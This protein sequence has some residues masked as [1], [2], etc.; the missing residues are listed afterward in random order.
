MVIKTN[1]PEG[2][3]DVNDQDPLSQTVPLFPQAPTVPDIVKD[4]DITVAP[5]GT[6]HVIFY[7]NDSSFYADYR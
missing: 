7:V 2:C 5:N 3:A 6:G 4:V 1:L